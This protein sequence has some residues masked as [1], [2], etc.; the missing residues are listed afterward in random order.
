MVSLSVVEDFK[1]EK[2]FDYAQTDFNVNIQ[3]TTFPTISLNQ[4]I[5]SKSNLTKNIQKI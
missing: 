2:V 5:Q 3:L 1:P 4:F